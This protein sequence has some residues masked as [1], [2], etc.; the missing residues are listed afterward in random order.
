MTRQGGVGRE[1]FVLLEGTAEIDRNGETVASIGPGDFF[2]EIALLC[3][4]PRTATITTTLP[5]RA[6]VITEASFRRLLRDQPG[7][8]GRVLDALA[9]RLAADE[10]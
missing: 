3:D 4:R 5:T 10:L 7:I 9:S 6:L 8:Q 1:F 2:G